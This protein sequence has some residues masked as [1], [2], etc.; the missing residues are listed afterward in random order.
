MIFYSDAVKLIFRDYYKA[1][2]SI[3]NSIKALGGSG[4]IHGCIVDIDFFNHVYLDPKDGTVKPYYAESIID[5]YEYKN[6][7]ALL[8]AKRPDLHKNYEKLLKAG[9]ET[10]LQLTENMNAK[11]IEISQYVPETTMY[12]PSKIMKSLQYLKDD[13]VIRY[14]NDEVIEF[15][16]KGNHELDENSVSR[17]YVALPEH[18]N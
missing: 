6:I 9:A 2:N 16:E 13:N 10:T 15:F 14:W 7:K 17:P 4:N 1:L 11:S 8:K 3:S 5:K 12:G 18:N